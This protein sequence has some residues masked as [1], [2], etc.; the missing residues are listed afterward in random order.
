MDEESRLNE[1]LLVANNGPHIHWLKEGNQE[2]QATRTSFKISTLF[3]YQVAW[4]FFVLFLFY[5]ELD[6]L[7]DEFN[8]RIFFCVTSGNI[9]LKAYMNNND[10][11]SKKRKF[12]TR[13]ENYHPYEL[14]QIII[15]GL[16]SA[17]VS[18]S[19][20]IFQIFL[21]LGI[22]ILFWIMVIRLTNS[23]KNIYKTMETEYF[24]Q[25]EKKRDE[26]EIKLE[27]QKESLRYL[28]DTPISHKI[29]VT[30]MKPIFMF[31]VAVAIFAVLSIFFNNLSNYPMHSKIMKK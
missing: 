7:E 26:E 4:S 1:P 20:F 23:K 15:L 18:L 2:P 6:D 30:K 12:Q 10:K 8:I 3:K 14:L 31:L 25:L 29:L 11:N 28:E 27:V 24:D 5:D 16:I 19:F 17:C 9:L 13:K 22:P 21:I